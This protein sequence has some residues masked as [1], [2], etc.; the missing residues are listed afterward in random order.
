VG[1]QPVY[2]FSWVIIIWLGIVNKVVTFFVWNNAR[3]I[4]RAVV[5]IMVMKVQL[6]DCVQTHKTNLC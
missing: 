2:L 6:N 1:I 3:A 5:F 4:T